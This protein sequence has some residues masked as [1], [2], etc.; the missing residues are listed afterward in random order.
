[1][2]A[3]ITHRKALATG[4]PAEI[5]REGRALADLVSGLPGFVACVAL[6]VDAGAITA[7]VLFDDRA[8][9]ESAIRPMT[10]WCCPEADACSAGRDHVIWGEVIAQKGL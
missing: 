10:D 5:G 8:S 4:T 7:L 6:E 1:M 3:S 9:L 2:Y